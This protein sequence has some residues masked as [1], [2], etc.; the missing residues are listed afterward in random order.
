MGE[1]TKVS[2]AR[3]EGLSHGNLEGWAAPGG[4]AFHQ[5][6][7]GELGEGKGPGGGRDAAAPGKGVE[8]LIVH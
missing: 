3:G 8:I 2:T 4:K 1:K 6:R 5:P 7:T